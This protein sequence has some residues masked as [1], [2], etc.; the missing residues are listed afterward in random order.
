MLNRIVT[1]VVAFPVAILLVAVA[2]INRHEVRMVLD[3]FKPQAPSLAVELPF[4]FYLFGALF[5]GVIVGGVAVWLGQGRWRRTARV[6]AQEGRR[7]QSEADRLAQERDAEVAR[8]GGTGAGKTLAL[9]H[10]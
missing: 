4:Y 7:W 9:G 8:S 10:R 6:R 1:L 3:P 5:L 2:V